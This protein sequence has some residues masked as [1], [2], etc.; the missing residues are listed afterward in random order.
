[1]VTDSVD[2]EGGTSVHSKR[3]LL[4]YASISGLQLV[5][6]LVNALDAARLGLF[7]AT[8]LHNSLLA[9]ILAAPMSFFHVTPLGRIVNRMSKDTT[10]VD[11]NLSGNLSMALR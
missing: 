11:R 6:Q 5:F 2:A 4:I 1:M 3:N 9:R 8:V 10:D 7:A